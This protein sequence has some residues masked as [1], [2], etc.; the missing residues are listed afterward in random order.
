M[1]NVI[2]GD[3]IDVQLAD[4]S[5][6]RVRYIGIDTPER[7][8]AC[9]PAA[10]AANQQ[11]VGGQR[12]RLEKDVSE[13]DQFGRLLRYVYVGDVFVN[14]EL[15]RQGEA[16]AKRYPPDTAKAEEFETLESQARLAGIGCIN[17]SSPT[18]TLV[19]STSPPV[20]IG[21]YECTGGQACIKG[22]INSEGE[23]IYHFPGCD[24]YNDTRIN[25][26]NGE[27]WFVTSQEAEAA[28]WRRARNCP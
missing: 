10:T 4:G 28:G 3:T 27:R 1:V 17:Q 7:D 15:V 16:E 26:N 19:I 21:G 9:G 13:T 23:K 20:I 25:P 14:A 6:V 24:S 12:V 8:E 22:N 2:D 5:V 11:L 18:A